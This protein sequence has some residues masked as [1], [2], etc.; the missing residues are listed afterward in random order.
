MDLNHDCAASLCYVIKL[1]ILSSTA[2]LTYGSCAL[3]PGGWNCAVTQL[4]AA[5][6]ILKAPQQ[7]LVIL[8][9][10][11]DRESYNAVVVSR[12]TEK[13]GA[14]VVKVRNIL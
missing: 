3:Q 6:V 7:K 11:I 4:L 5:A 9:L 1:T 8:S 14:S 13:Y 2:R 10:F 12:A